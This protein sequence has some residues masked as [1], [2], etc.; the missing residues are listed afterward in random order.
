MNIAIISAV[1][2]DN[3]AIGYKNDLCFKLKKDLKHFKELTLGHTI[4]M[5]ENTFKSLPN[6]PL[7]GRRNIVLTENKD[8]GCENY[9]TLE[10]ALEACKNED[11]VFII[12][13]G[14]LYRTSLHLANVLYITEI[15]SIPEN[16]DTFFPEYRDK[17]TLESSEPEEENGI[18]FYFTKYVQVPIL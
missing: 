17:F 9:A 4:I 1:A 13:G 16:A 11:T 2:K 7:P 8:I 5:G 18:K 12:G 6:G 14:M 15:D 3:L 10:E